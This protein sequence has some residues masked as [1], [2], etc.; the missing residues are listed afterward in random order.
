M[1]LSCWNEY[2]LKEPIRNEA[3]L[4]AAELIKKVYEF[5]G[6]GGNCHVVLED[7]NLEDSNIE[8][9][10]RWLDGKECNVPF[11]D[12]AQQLAERECMDAMMKLS[13]EERASALRLTYDDDCAE[14]EDMGYVTFVGVQNP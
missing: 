11:G 14:D 5:S 8:F 7:W 4:K 9:T 13:V 1:C 3:T 12:S 6:V 2:G 10:Y